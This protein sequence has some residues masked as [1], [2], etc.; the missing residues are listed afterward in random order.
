MFIMTEAELHDICCVSFARWSVRRCEVK[1][2]GDE[3][4]WSACMRCVENPNAPSS[5]QESCMFDEVWVTSPGMQIPK[6]VGP[7][8]V[9]EVCSQQAQLLAWFC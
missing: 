3:L 4:A 6:L 7:H 9:H 5:N 1:H 2:D 8:G